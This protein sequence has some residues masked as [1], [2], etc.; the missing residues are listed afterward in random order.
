MLSRDCTCLH[1]SRM[2]ES[3]V[4]H[5]GDD[6]V[7]EDDDVHDQSGVNIFPNGSN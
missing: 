7:R 1:T 4:M 5:S 2:N 6:D 3:G